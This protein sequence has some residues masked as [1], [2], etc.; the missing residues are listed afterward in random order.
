MYFSFENRFAKYGGVREIYIKQFS[1][2][3]SVWEVNLNR[4]KD[5]LRNGF[6][7]AYVTYVS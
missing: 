7:C 5:L 4:N 2:S 1:H 3:V 6:I